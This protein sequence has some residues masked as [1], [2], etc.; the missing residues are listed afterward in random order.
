MSSEPPIKS[1]RKR[2]DRRSGIGFD[3]LIGVERTSPSVFVRLVSPAARPPVTL[4][5]SVLRWR[6]LGLGIAPGG[7]SP[8]LIHQI[9]DL[10][11]RLLSLADDQDAAEDFGGGMAAAVGPRVGRDAIA[12]HD[13]KM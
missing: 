8:H 6:L 7:G 12:D 2:R 13:Y 1:H 5:R 3:S 11:Q 4:E 9:A 10:R